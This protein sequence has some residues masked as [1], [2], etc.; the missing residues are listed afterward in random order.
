MTPDR[1]DKV[2]ASRDGHQ[3]HEAWVARHA[4]GLLLARGRAEDLCGIAVEGLSPEDGEAAADEAVEI[5]DVTL[6]FGDGVS[7]DACAGLE[8]AQLKYSISK[9]DTPFRMADAKKTLGKF[10]AA[11]ADFTIK[12]GR[13]AVLE[14][15]RYA[16]V[17]NRPIDAAA[18]D[19]VEAAAAGIEPA[20]QEA[21]DQHAALKTATGLEGEALAAFAR[22]LSFSG[23][24]PELRRLEHGN[25]R[26]LVDWSASDDLS[27]GK[28]L[29][30]L[31][32]LVRDKAGFAGQKDNLITVVEV[33]HALGVD[34]EQ[35]LLPTPAAFV[36]IGPVI[37]RPQLADFAAGL[38]DTGT[39]LVTAAG[40]LGKTV[41][42]QSLAEH[43]RARDEVVL[44]DCFGGGAWRAPQDGR[45]RPERGRNRRGGPGAPGAGRGG[46]FGEP[47]RLRLDRRRSPRRRCRS[48]E[49]RRDARSVRHA[50]RPC[51]V[52]PA[53]SSPR[54]H[55]RLG[56]PRPL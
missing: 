45:H 52:R 32:A 19:A 37:E 5:A 13:D 33:L 2:R 8:V 56:G 11:D 50:T 4:L 21:K 41:F 18:L 24:V 28:R 54:R 35:D 16:L 25:G 34:E 23:R 49:A 3:F 14:K 48:S 43:L 53:K 7:F 27:A 51:T 38:G 46:V 42:L 20:G 17:T 9:A 29:G 44:F 10:V 12:H 6:Y 40:G 39:W 31:R 15:V 26:T 22:R 47:A 30:D 55:R 1:V 36:D